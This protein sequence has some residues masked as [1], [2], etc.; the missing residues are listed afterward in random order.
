MEKNESFLK[1][2]VILLIITATAGLI[3]GGVHAITKK[4]IAK[5]IEKTNNEAMK[6]IVPQADSFT[7][8][9]IEST[10]IIK[11]VNE[12]KASNDVVGYAFKVASKGYGGIIE[13][14][15]GISKDGKIQGIKILS[16]SETPGLG[17]NAE[18]PD[19][20]GRF[21]DKPTDK[22]LK[23]VKRT[24]SAPNEIQAMTGATITS[25]AVTL[26]VNEVVKFYNEQ[27]KG[28]QK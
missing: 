11:E 15:V 7:K 10:D 8:M 27:L 22:S 24:A 14:M 13:M 19:F 17:A 12:G 25:R 4:P 28:G 26:G 9:K 1:L 20:S 21:K 5:Q 16:H 23:V 18:K 2:G 3:L 6:E